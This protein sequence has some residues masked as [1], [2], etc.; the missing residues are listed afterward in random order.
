MITPKKAKKGVANHA[1]VRRELRIPHQ[2]GFN[3]AEATCPNRMPS[4]GGL[5]SIAAHGLYRASAP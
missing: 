4:I 5:V 3:S 2:T 1:A